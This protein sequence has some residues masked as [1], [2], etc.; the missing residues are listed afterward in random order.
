MHA[1]VHE[2]AL[3][4][5]AFIRGSVFDALPPRSVGLVKP[6]RLTSEA[7]RSCKAARS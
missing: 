2:F 4:I 3:L 7:Q 5:L 1:N 6:F